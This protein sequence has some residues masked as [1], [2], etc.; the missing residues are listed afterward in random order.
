MLAA[1]KR[2]LVCLSTNERSAAPEGGRNPFKSGRP[3]SSVPRVRSACRDDRSCE[4]FS[5]AGPRYACPTH[6]AGVGEA[7]VPE[8]ALAQVV[9]RARV[10]TRRALWGLGTA[11]QR[12]L[13]GGTEGCACVRSCVCS[14]SDEGAAWQGVDARRSAVV[15]P[16]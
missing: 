2:M 14:G 13:W 9:Q 5:D 3:M 12:A 6:R 16:M 7:T 11:A 4:G 1:I 15:T 10:A 8:V